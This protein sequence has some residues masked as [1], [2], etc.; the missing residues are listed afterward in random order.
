MQQLV[1][2]LSYRRLAVRRVG[3]GGCGQVCVRCFMCILSGSF[4][5]VREEKTSCYTSSAVKRNGL[6]FEFEDALVV[7]RVYR[8]QQAVGA[9]A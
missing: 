6:N 8:Q 1:L 9:T 7:Y 2:G 5:E 3:A 4:P